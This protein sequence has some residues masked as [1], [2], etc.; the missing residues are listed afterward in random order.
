VAAGAKRSNKFLA[1][2]RDLGDAIRQ[3]RR[4]DEFHDQEWARSLARVFI[5]M[6]AAQGVRPGFLS[7]YSR[8]CDQGWPDSCERIG[9]SGD[10][11][12]ASVPAAIQ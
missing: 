3:R 1:R 2:A 12:Q 4:V 6:S 7:L 9:G 10:H 5:I 8:A 11:H